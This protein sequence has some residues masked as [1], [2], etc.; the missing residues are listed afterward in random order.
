MPNG[1]LVALLAAGLLWIP[2]RAGAQLGP[3]PPLPASADTNS[4]EA[5]YDRGVEELKLHRP[6]S[7]ELSFYWAPLRAELVVREQLTLGT[8]YESKEMI[9]YARAMLRIAQGDREGGRAS[10]GD[11]LS[12]NLGFYPAHDLLGQ[13]AV[14]AGDTATPIRKSEQA[15]QIAPGDA[16]MQY[17]YGVALLAALRPAD[18]VTP[19]RRAVTDA[20]WYAAPYYSLAVALTGAGQADSART[21][22]ERYLAIAPRSDSSYVAV[23]RR[24]LTRLAGHGGG[25]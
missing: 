21:A 9:D 16:V 6:V 22:F 19:L 25:R 12:E 7:A 15:V 10:L 24:E 5:Y 13:L 8:G 11:A 14:A 3:R 20:P 2:A 17:R 18:A 23:A 1:T 4:W